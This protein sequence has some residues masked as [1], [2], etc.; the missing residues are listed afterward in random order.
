TEVGVGVKDKDITVAGVD[1]QI[2]HEW[3][4]AGYVVGKYPVGDK[5]E[6]FARGG[7]GH[8]ELKQELAGSE[9]K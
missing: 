9:S 8:T 5:L 6:L 4:A 1:G 7:Y 2:K 3:D